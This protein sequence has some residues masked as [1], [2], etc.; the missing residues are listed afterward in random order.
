M[1]IESLQDP[2]NPVAIAI[3]AFAVIWELVWKAIALWK[4]ARNGHK[5]W[6][7]GFFVYFL[8]AHV[9]AIPEIIYLKFF[10]NKKVTPTTTKIHDESPTN[11]LKSP[12]KKR[13]K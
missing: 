13:V 10:Q 1:N 7:I 4:S 6:F 12:K 2:K 3:F 9:W 11:L 5:Y 8:F